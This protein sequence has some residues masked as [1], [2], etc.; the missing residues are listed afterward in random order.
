MAWATRA[1]AELA[2]ENA[3]KP[4]LPRMLAVAPV[5]K[6]LPRPR[7]SR[8]ARGLASDQESGVARPAP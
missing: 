5:K 2:D 8:I 3:A 1:K 4:L 7:W 6:M